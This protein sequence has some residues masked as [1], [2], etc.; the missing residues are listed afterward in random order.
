M[1]I[2]LVDSM[3]GRHFPLRLQASDIEVISGSGVLDDGSPPVARFLAESLDFLAA[4]ASAR[5]DGRTVSWC[6]VAERIRMVGICAAAFALR[7]EELGSGGSRAREYAVI[8]YRT[9]GAGRPDSP[10]VA[11]MAFPSSPGI[12]A[13][14]R[15]QILERAVQQLAPW[16]QAEEIAARPV[17]QAAG[18]AA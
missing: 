10:S 9:S 4:T 2:H 14:A 13:V 7:G 12:D 18:Q 6:E 3:S 8:V 16:S 15:R 17:L 1:T 5:E 11:S